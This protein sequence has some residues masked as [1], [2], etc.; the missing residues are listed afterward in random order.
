MGAQPIVDPELLKL[1]IGLL[2][3][4]TRYVVSF[5]HPFK[6]VAE[7]FKSNVPKDKYV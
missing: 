1:T 5:A 2:S 3:L 7:I 4:I 6:P